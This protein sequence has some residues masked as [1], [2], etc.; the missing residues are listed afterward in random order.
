MPSKFILLQKETQLF[1]RIYAI[2]YFIQAIIFALFPKLVLNDVFVEDHLRLS[3]KFSGI[4]IGIIL[5][6][7]GIA[8]IG[9][10]NLKGMALRMFTRIFIFNEML[11]FVVPLFIWSCGKTFPVSVVVLH[12]I[13]LLIFVYLYAKQVPKKY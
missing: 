9:V 6:C 4:T 11:T 2:G 10:S 8:I 3:D 7:F 12:A 5:L 13:Q 1:M